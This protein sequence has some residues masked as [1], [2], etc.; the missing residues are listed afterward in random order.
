[1]H[2]QKELK[3]GTSGDHDHY[4]AEWSPDGF[5][6]AFVS[7]RDRDWNHDAGNRT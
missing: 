5:L 4:D 3:Q 6:I 7:H 2:R 1:V